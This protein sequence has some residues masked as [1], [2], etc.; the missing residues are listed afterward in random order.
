LE[1]GEFAFSRFPIPFWLWRRIRGILVIIEGPGVKVVKIVLISL[2]T[3]GLAAGAIVVT[4]I[5]P[6]NIIGMIRY[7]QREE[8]SLRVGDRAP[9]VE[10]LALDGTATTRL[11]RHLGGRPVVLVFGSFT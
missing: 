4:K 9:D 3:V 11:S 7:D 5:G 2:L 1:I 10:L 8:G 6:R